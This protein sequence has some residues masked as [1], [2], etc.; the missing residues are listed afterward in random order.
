MDL[1]KTETNRYTELGEFLKARRNKIKPE[2]IGISVGTR[3]RTPGLRREEVAQ[4]AGIGIT[5]YT[6]LEQGREIN[7][8]D[9]ILDSLSRVFMLTKEERSHLYAL[10][11]KSL[12]MQVEPHQTVNDSVLNFFAKFDLLYCP[13]FITDGY[14]NLVKWNKYAAFVFGDFSQLP[15]NEQNTIHLMFCN[16][17]YMSLFEYWEYHAKEMLARFH[18]TFAKHNDDPWFIRFI[19]EM[20][21]KSDSFASW[22]ALHDVNSMTNIVKEV[23]HP[24]VGK[25]IFDF[26]SFDIF[27]NQDYK[28]L[29]Y[30]PDHDSSI[31]L[32]KVADFSAMQERYRRN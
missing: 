6:W 27:D 23:K 20:K 32:S 21:S 30:N 2:H 22:W 31:K 19:E 8:S 29:V 16:Q 5:W 15:T 10:A 7:V 3:R 24:A 11:N 18:A 26:V 12:S 14:W 25:L 4:L 28:L 9:A 1:K 17:D 13:A